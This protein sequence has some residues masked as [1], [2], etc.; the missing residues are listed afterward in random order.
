[1]LR[2]PMLAAIA[3]AGSSLSSA[4]AAEDEHARSGCT[5]SFANFDVTLTLDA[6]LGL[7][8]VQN[9]RNGA[10][11]QSPSGRN[12][13]SRDWIEGFLAPGLGFDRH[14]GEST[15]SGGFKLVVWR[16]QAGRQTHPR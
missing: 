10:G 8:L 5:H 4:I 3:A 14:A 6:E 7:F 16:L 15:V 11:S 2:N 1:M 13:G 9:A 12:R